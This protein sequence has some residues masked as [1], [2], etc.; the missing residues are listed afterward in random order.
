M[1]AILRGSLFA[2]A[3]AQLTCAWAHCDDDPSCPKFGEV[4]NNPTHG[5]LS[6][7]AVKQ[8]MPR[9]LLIPL[10]IKPPASAPDQL[11][12]AP[13]ARPL[14]ETN[15][16]GNTIAP[17]QG[18]NT[19]PPAARPL[20]P[21]EFIRANK[22]VRTKEDLDVVKM[23]T[24]NAVRQLTNGRATVQAIQSSPNAAGG[25]GLVGSAGLNMRVAL[26]E[27]EALNRIMGEAVTAS[28]NL[29]G[30]ERNPSLQTELERTGNL[31]QRV[32]GRR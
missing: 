25:Q 12:P 3:L 26:D 22:P 28:R 7:P 10:V 17:S 6:N 2:M 1:I 11:P 29:Q 15:L 19:R 27:L 18:G 20:T 9:I 8:D 30:T 32:N 16:G 23:G 4:L 21:A 14:G 5:N 13:L 31:L 24:L